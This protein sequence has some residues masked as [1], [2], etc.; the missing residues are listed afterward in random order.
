[1][2][3]KKCWSDIPGRPVSPHSHLRV[4]PPAQSCPHLTDKA[5]LFPWI[6]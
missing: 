6:I 1:M 2:L 4:V 5:L 3:Y